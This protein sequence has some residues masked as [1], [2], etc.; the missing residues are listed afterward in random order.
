MTYV[1]K[2]HYTPEQLDSAAMADLIH[3]AELAEQQATEGPFYPERDIT[4]ESL[5]A[6]AADCRAK[7]A[8]YV[9][10]GLHKAIMQ[11]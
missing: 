5:L 9:G 8:K 11:G 6:Y 7:A 2:Q 3:D 1:P 4:A 10:G